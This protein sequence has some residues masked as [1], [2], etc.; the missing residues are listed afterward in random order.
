[1]TNF[2]DK[3]MSGEALDPMNYLVTAFVHVGAGQIN[4][5]KVDM[6]P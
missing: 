2:L 1:M 5:L 3:Y 6:S 4:K